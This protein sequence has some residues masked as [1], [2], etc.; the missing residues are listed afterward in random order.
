M[1]LKIAQTANK[2]GVTPKQ[3]VDEIRPVSAMARG[4][5]ART[6]PS[7]APPNRGNYNSFAGDLGSA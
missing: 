2:A 1:R 3:L 4:P 7:F 6:M 5:I